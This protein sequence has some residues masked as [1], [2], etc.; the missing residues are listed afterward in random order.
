MLV[1]EKK[2]TVEDF[3]NMTF[4]GEEDAYYELINGEIMKKS[5]PTSLHQDISDNLQYAL[6]CFV[7][8]KKLGKVYSAPLD[9]YLHRFSHVL[10]DLTYVSAAKKHLVDPTNG[11][12]GVP[13]IL[14]E[15]I[16][17]SSVYK[18]RVLKN[19]DYEASGVPEYWL[20]D[21]KNQSIE[22]YENVN[23]EFQLFAFAAEEG[24][25]QS[26]VLAG[27]EVDLREVFP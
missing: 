4:E 5:A 7:R 10:P 1:A 25:V 18:D 22:V 15:I 8:P 26:K 21:A 12:V 3:D 6:N 23:G 2:I 17:P 24:K 13:D 16:S 9:V 14:I 19:N 27:F 11:V 20:V